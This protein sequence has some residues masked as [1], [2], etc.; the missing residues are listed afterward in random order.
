VTA[1]EGAGAAGD[2]AGEAAAQAAQRD[3]GPVG[4]EAALERL[5]D[6]APGPGRRARRMLV[7]ANPYATTTR[8]RL[9][10]VVV[11]ALQTHY[12]VEAVDTQRPGHASELS[13][14]AAH[15]GYD[16]VL[17]FGGDGTV[18]EVANGLAGTSTA[19]T[20]LPGGATNVYCRMLG[21]STDVVD[22]TAHILDLAA[23]PPVQVDLARV[24]DRWFTFS[25]GAGLDAAVVA[26][27]DA[28]PRLKARF[29]PWFY[30]QSATATFL[31]RYIVNPPRVV[32]EV[33]GSEV[34]GVSVFVQNAQ[35]YTFFSRR[36]VRL[37]EGARID[38]GDI[39]GVVLTRANA[40]DMPTITFR[41]LA[42]RVR[43]ER[44][45]RVAAFDGLKELRVR[46]FDER[47]VP[48]Q[49]DGDY[50]GAHEEAQFSV[51]PGGLFVL[52]DHGLG[53]NAAA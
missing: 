12:E 48:V 20:C 11:A 51:R 31:A 5:A 18:N 9:V 21:L 40:L 23:T 15:D 50:I 6:S 41:L 19:L 17:A 49:V 42:Q 37:A 25:A 29:G 43:V 24:N 33:G 30:A 53:G 28:N 34:T 35:P 32:A 14:E 38:S 45:R 13:R 36:P 46:S 47:P 44:H 2:T 3:P 22:A 7:I 8:P 10:Q 26:R 4:A 27:V 16:L 39:S 1:G 52:G